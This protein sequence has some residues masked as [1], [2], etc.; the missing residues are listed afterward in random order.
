VDQARRECRGG[1]LVC[2]R[3]ADEDAEREELEDDPSTACP[4]AE[5]GQRKWTV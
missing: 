4:G 5:L 3:L 2:G 1:E